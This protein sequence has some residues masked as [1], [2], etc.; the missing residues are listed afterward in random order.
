MGDG[1]GKEQDFASDATPAAEAEDIAA[2]EGEI[3]E[4]DEG[5]RALPAQIGKSLHLAMLTMDSF[6]RKGG[7]GMPSRPP[8]S[9][10]GLMEA[11]GDKK[12]AFSLVGSTAVVALLE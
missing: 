12:N 2:G 6:L 9:S 5:R 10:L 4:R 3:A 7:D 1:S 11:Y 8:Q